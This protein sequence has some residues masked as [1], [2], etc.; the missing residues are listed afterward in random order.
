MFYFNLPR[1]HEMDK[2]KERSNDSESKEKTHSSIKPV[3]IP[4]KNKVWLWIMACIL[5]GGFIA[6][7]LII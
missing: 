4:E 2:L 1:G 3:P 6:L 5:I 7:F